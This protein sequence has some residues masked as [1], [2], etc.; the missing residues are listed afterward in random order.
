VTE[1]IYRYNCYTSPDKAL[2]M[3]SFKLETTSRAEEIAK[4]I[5]VLDD[6]GMKAQDISDNEM[7]KSHARYMIGGAQSVPNERIFRFGWFINDCFGFCSENDSEFPE[8]PGALRNFLTGMRQEWNISMFHYRNHGADLGKV[9]AGIQVPPSDSAAFDDFLHKLN[10]T[11]VEETD[12]PIYKQYLQ[13][14][15]AS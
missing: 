5:S 7:A 6:G 2:V 14:S 9:L 4:L 10:Y 3:F 12:N 1:F 13:G 8:R 11:Y 15:K